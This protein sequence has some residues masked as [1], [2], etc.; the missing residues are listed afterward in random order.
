MELKNALEKLSEL[1]RKLYAYRYAANAIY[2]DSV[3]AAPSD[4]E[5]GR[6][7]AMGEISG[8]AYELTTAPETIELLE[9]LKEKSGELTPH[10]ARE[11]ELLLRD[12]EYISSIPQD[13]YVAF[14]VLS[15]KSESVWHR[16]KPANDYAMFMPYLRDMMATSARFAKYYKPEQDPYETLLGQ[17]E[18]GLTMAKCDEFFG[19]L[20]ANIVPLLKKISGKPQIDDSPLYGDFPVDRQKELTE[21]IMAFMTVDPRHCTCGETEHPFTIE[22]NKD[23]VRITTHYHTDSVTSSLYSVVH[24]SGHALYELGGAAEHMY[25]VVAGGVSMGIHESQSRFFENILGRSEAFTDMLLP[26]LRR[27][28]PGKFDWIP[29]REFYRMINKSEPSLIRTEADEL[30]YPL[31]IMV[32]YELEKRLIHGELSVEELP[33]E[34]NRL[35]SEY[36]G[37]EVPDDTHG[38]LQ[39]SHWSGGQIGYFPSYALG[40]AYGAQFLARMRQDL[41]PF[42]AIRAGDM[43]P[44]VDWL[45]DKIYRHASMYDPN[46]LLEMVAGAPFDPQYYVDYLENKYSDVYGL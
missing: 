11:V 9:G 20:R 31:H 44:I 19:K 42:A 41:D 35:Y 10:Q 29:S 36:L 2:L 38:V 16:A 39:D 6:S 4:T 45:G 3:T 12:H 7:V 8:F 26:E 33:A 46:T 37:V 27:L 5:E 23:D 24:E 13:E 17:Y 40:S 28:F 32:R 22:F 18:R 14:Q 43:K 1:Q 15:T 21:R 25:T 30:T 34:W